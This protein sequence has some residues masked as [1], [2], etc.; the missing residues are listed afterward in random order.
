MSRALPY[1]AFLEG[2][3]ISLPATGVDGASVQKMA[4]EVLRLL[5]SEVEWPFHPEHMQKHAVEFHG[6]IHHIFRQVAVVPFRLLSVFEDAGAL[7]A[8]IAEHAD[9]FIADL[10]RLKSVVQ[11]ECVIYPA[12]SKPQAAAAS[13]TSYLQEKAGML[14]AVEQQVS[15]VQGALGNLARDVRIRE[16]KS[17]T[18]IFVL[19]ERG[20]EQEFRPMIE[21]I[22]LPVPLSR[23]VS[24]PWPAAEFLSQQVQAPKAAEVK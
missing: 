1:C 15:Q 16:A 19:V 23:R 13:G 12:P 3:Q 21:R 14:R 22:P 4:P 6:V 9:V 7:R 24:G 20:R 10:E 17:G 18:R 8:F 5:W 11:M 2:P